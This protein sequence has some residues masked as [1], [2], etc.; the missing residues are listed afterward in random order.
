MQSCASARGALAAAIFPSSHTW[1]QMCK[2]FWLLSLSKSCERLFAPSTAT[3]A[4]I[5]S[6]ERELAKGSDASTLSP[7]MRV[8]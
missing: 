5:S 2:S 6:D 8:G 7:S 1:L 3:L 4:E